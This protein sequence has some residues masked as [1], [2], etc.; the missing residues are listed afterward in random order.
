MAEPF[1]GY[2]L[3]FGGSFAPRGYA[4]CDGQILSIDQYTALFTL[5]GTTYGGDGQET[6]AL[7]DLRGRIPI[8]QGA[9]PGPSNRTIG[10]AAGEEE[11]TL[12]S[13]TMPLH[14]HQV[15]ATNTASSLV[16]PS[17]TVWA[18][19]GSGNTLTYD[20]ATPNA[21]MSPS[22]TTPS[23]G[24]QPHENQ[25]PSLSIMFAIALEGIFPSQN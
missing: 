15:L 8:H 20:L 12:I 21:L 19:E 17:G 25:H 9:G 11:V 16:S 5:I 10:E 6:F 1:I 23:G 13:S 18:R 7:P 2:I 14:T 4:K 3:M 24:S 22:A